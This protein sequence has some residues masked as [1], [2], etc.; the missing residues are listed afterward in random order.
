MKGRV[1]LGTVTKTLRVD[2]EFVNIVNDYVKLVK[3]VFGFDITANSV[4]A[5][6]LVTGFG[7]YLN[8]FKLLISPSVKLTASYPGEKLPN[9]E[10]IDKIK[11][12]V[13]RCEDYLALCEHGSTLTAVEEVKTIDL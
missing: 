10:Q 6:S 2:E 4:L 7:N 1:I 3:E 13:E 8:S 9:Q 12:F 11:L 5:G